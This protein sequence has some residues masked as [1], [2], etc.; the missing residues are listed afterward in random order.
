MKA[1]KNWV[2]WKYADR[3]NSKG[4]MKKTKVP[5]QINGRLA[6][7]NNPDT[8]ASFENIIK[9]LNRYP[10]KYSGIGF[11]FSPDSGLMG[12]DF[13]HVKNPDTGEWD[14]EA[15]K[16]IKSLN[17]YTEISPSGTGAHVIVKGRVPLSQDEIEAGR[18]GKKN[19]NIGR[20]MYHSKR[21]FTITGE[22]MGEATQIINP[23]QAAVNSLYYKWFSER[24]KKNAG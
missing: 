3:K 19:Q 20:E 12:L 5:Y 7:S 24:D 14:P 15:L 18:T 10:D 22:L 11:M 2:L 1:L 8:W 23:A 4:E 6:E 13:D 17:S 9:I 21:F 16:E